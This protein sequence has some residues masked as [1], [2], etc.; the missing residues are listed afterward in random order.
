MQILEV[1][2]KSYKS[3]KKDNLFQL[4]EPNAWGVI[5][6]LGFLA[7]W[8]VNQDFKQIWCYVT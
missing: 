5:I 8:E 6:T 1:K 7:N 4:L 3:N 2:T